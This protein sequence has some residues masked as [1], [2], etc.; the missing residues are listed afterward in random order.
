VDGASVRSTQ[1]GSAVNVARTP[2]KE[3]SIDRALGAEYSDAQSGVIAFVTRGGGPSFDGA[4]AYETDEM[5][6]DGTSVGLNRAEVSLGGPIMNNLTFFVAGTIDGQQSSARQGAASSRPAVWALDT[7][8]IE[9]DPDDAG[10]GGHL[11]FVQYGGDCDAA[12]NFG[13]ECQGARR[14]YNWSTSTTGQG[15]LQYTYGSGSRVSGTFLYSQDQSRG[16]NTGFAYQRSSGTRTWGNA[17]ILNW[18]QQIARSA[19][20][21]L[22][23]D[24]NLSPDQQAVV[25]PMTQ[26]FERN[27]RSPFMGWQFG[28]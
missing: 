6:G 21:A 7:T 22:A 1:T 19:E 16:W 10:R 13:V 28:S 23:L 8:V 9:T 20:R 18:T 3:A 12:L 26:E 5:F 11:Q 24:V 25:G 4:I 17:Y 27:N 15:K 14:P 2:S